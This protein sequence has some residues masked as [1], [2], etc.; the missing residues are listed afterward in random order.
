MTAGEAARAEP[1]AGTGYDEEAVLVGEMARL[2]T[3]LLSSFSQEQR[4]S[5]Q[6][7]PLA[8]PRVEEE[9]VRWYYTP[10]DHG[11]LAVRDMAPRQQS[12]VMQLVATGLSRAAYVTLCTVMGLENVL[13]EL[14]GWTR[15]WGRE[16]GRDP[17]LYWLRVF[18]DPVGHTWGWRFGGHHV[19]VNMLLSGTSIVA[20]TPTFL[21]ADPAVSPLLGGALRPLGGVEDLAREL[22]ASLDAEQLRDGL[23][24]PS[25]VS[26]IVSGNRPRIR[27]GDTMMHMQDLFRGPL[28]DGRLATLVDRI[29]E[30]A[31]SG[32][33]YTDSDHRAM[34]LDDGA[35]GLP[36]SALD[37]R[38]R[39]V[40]R[41][42]LA[43]FT[44][45]SPGTVARVHR[46]RY[47][48]DDV[49]DQ[50]RFGWAGSRDVGA[51]HY[52][53]LSGPRLLAEYDNTQRDANH[54]HTVW[55]DPVGGFGL[56]PMRSHRRT[57]A[58]P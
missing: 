6:W 18:G 55:R 42:L 49:L 8:D 46:A 10:T 41:D 25:A 39:A 23:L 56:D 32:S 45:R 33:G 12:L 14:E 47:Q 54:A 22:V 31:E 16:R 44:D 43:T 26:D 53:R 35:R 1:P 4:R 24:H 34:A 38:Q 51:P 28:P 11:G 13:D 17:G 2:A 52:F 58:H 3:E 27:P 21:G 50:V 7:T 19:S 57:S 9:R 48:R 37:Q 15:D 5:A 20:V 40:L 29:D 36:A 30:V